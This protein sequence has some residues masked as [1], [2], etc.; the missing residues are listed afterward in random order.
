[1]TLLRAF[2]RAMPDPTEIVDVEE[3]RVTPVDEFPPSIIIDAL[4]MFGKLVR[5]RLH[6]AHA[7][8]LSDDL[9]RAAAHARRKDK[10]KPE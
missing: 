9:L 2:S 6:A 8:K 7:H 4:T 5:L 3:T 10:E 1:V